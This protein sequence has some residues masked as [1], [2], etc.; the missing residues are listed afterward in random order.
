MSDVLT[1]DVCGSHEVDEYSSPDGA[2]HGFYCAAHA[3]AAWDE[4]GS[5]PVFREATPEAY[6]DPSG[7]PAPREEDDYILAMRPDIGA[8]D[9]IRL[10]DL[11][12]S[13]D[14]EENDK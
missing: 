1:C 9:M 13:T 6:A 12:T 2:W 8:C 10:S 14:D 5:V 4:Y 7:P 11:T 3:P